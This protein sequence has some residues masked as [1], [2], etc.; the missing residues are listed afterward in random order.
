MELKETARSNLRAEILS[1]GLALN[2]F[3]GYLVA[4]L[5]FLAL[6]GAAW[7]G[8]F[9]VPYEKPAVTV[10]VPNAWHPN[11]S[12]EGVD[13]AS[14]DRSVFMTIYTFE[15]SDCREARD[16]ALKFLTRNGMTIDQASAQ[17]SVQPI[18]GVEAAR[19][20]YAAKE[21]ARDRQLLV[22]VAPVRANEC[23]QI[24]QWGAANGFQKNEAGL[25][26]IVASIKRT[27]K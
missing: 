11:Q 22:I 15:T 4:V 24:A 5:S 7:A 21:D 19:T 18:A 12:P 16:D 20:R 27:G 25:A 6:P 1:W 26:K 17:E 3:R 23:L 2:I 8:T 9:D 13:V 14:P 10:V